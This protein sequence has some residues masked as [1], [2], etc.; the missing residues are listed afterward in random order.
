MPRSLDTIDIVVVQ[1]MLADCRR[2]DIEIAKFLELEEAEVSRRIASL[3]EDGIIRNFVAR[4]NPSY[5]RAVNVFIFGTSEIG[6]LEEAKD[7]LSKNDSSSW[8]GLAGGSRMYVAA[9]LRRLMHLD[10]FVQFLREDVEMKDL[11]FGIRSGLPIFHGDKPPLEAVDYRIL[12]SLRRDARKSLFEV[13]E[14]V[15][16]ERATV[17]ARIRRMRDEGAVEFSIELDPESTSDILCMVHLWR[18][19]RGELK[20]FMRE[21]LNE[22]SPRI[23]FFNQYRN[24]TDLTVTMCW[25]RDMVGLRTI[26]GSFRQNPDFYHIEAN[27]LI[28]T[29]IIEDWADRMIIERSASPTGSSSEGPKEVA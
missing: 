6:S 12:S 7:K 11:T 13:G 4:I 28:T 26:L 1:M 29:G 17:E 24:L 5:L 3:R 8:V 9:T 15:G 27:P 18:K 22:H 2:P 23:L 25:V 21:K 10:S 16:L 20:P 14:E 19:G